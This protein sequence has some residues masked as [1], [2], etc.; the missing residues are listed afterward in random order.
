MYGMVNGAI[1]KLIISKYGEST[2]ARVQ[3]QAGLNA[4]GFLS[5]E[6]YEDSISVDMVVAL[7]QL[8]EKTPAQVLEEIGEYWIEFAHNSEYGALLEMAGDTLPEVLMNLD[9]M[10]TRIGQS[11]SDLKPPSFWCTEVTDNSLLLHYASLRDGLSPMIIGL[12]KGLGTLLNVEV[13]VRQVTE[14]GE[15]DEF[16]TF[17]VVFEPISDTPSTPHTAGEVTTSV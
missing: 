9:D 4:D 15:E 3:E 2:W 14:K 1:Q 17:S 5:M 6:Q 11:F 7:S 13:E 8:C 16:A 10:H 12:L